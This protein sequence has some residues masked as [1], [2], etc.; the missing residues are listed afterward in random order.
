MK[1]QEYLIARPGKKIDHNYWEYKFTIK[2]G[3]LY[4]ILSV[5]DLGTDTAYWMDNRDDIWTAT[6][7]GNGI[8]I[9]VPAP[10]NRTMKAAAE[11]TK[12]WILDH[13]EILTEANNGERGTFYRMAV[14]KW[15]ERD[16]NPEMIEVNHYHYKDH[17]KWID[18]VWCG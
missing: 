10:Y 13:L 16:K 11:W 8:K 4:E 9:P 14:E 15:I 2:E 7:H 18:E 17:G 5:K 12:E 6:C 1:K 3:Y